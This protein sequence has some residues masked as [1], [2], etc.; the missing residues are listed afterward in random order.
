MVIITHAT[1]AT[2]TSATGSKNPFR[3]IVFTVFAQDKG[4][5]TPL[6]W[7]VLRKKLCYFAY[8]AE[9]CP[10]TGRPHHQGFAYA[11]TAMRF[12][13][14]V[15][16]LNH[17]EE[18][19]YIDF[20]EMKGSFASNQAYCSKEGK[21]IEFGERPK[22]GKRTDLIE[23]KRLL[24]EG[25]RP[26]EIADEY[27][28]HF[29]TVMK[30]SKGMSEY[31]DYKRRKLL[32]NDRSQPEVYIRWGPPGTGKTRWV[33]DNYGTNWS[34]VPDNKGQWFDH[35]DSDVVLFD[36]VKINEV[37]PIGKILQLTDRYPI[38]VAKKGGFITWKPRVIVFTSN[39]PPEQW[40]NLSYNDKN[41]QAFMR[42]VTKIEEVVYK[43]P[44][45]HGDQ[46][47]ENLDQAQDLS[48][49]ESEDDLQESDG[50]SQA[51]GPASYCSYS[52]NEE[53]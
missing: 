34:R 37:P 27:E 45:D 24:D 21:L 2:K 44:E 48:R 25:K 53:L 30:F 42:R 3:S 15:E 16:L 19:S 20:Q 47:K 50:S 33:D 7:E 8:G 32:Q 43:K 26:M 36:D 35:C 14:W 46:T 41:Y 49:E 17:I 51:S 31:S 52:G 5:P 18:N 23:V 28:E 9:I 1:S 40:W 22:Q 29:S 10:T 38:Q 12:G 13:A 4:D 39:Y 6:N 11:R